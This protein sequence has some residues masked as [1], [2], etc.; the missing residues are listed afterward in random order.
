MY[1]VRLNTGSAGQQNTGK[2]SQYLDPGLIR[3]AILVPFD[4]YCAIDPEDTPEEVN[5]K[6]KAALKDALINDVDKYRAQI[7]GPFESMEDKTAAGGTQTLGF[8][9]V[10]DT[11]DAVIGFDFSFV[12]GGLEY[13]QKVKSFSG[14]TKQYKVVF[15]D[16][17]GTVYATNH[18]TYV[19]VAG[20]I[21]AH[22][23]VDGCKGI[24]LSRLHSDT[25]KAPNKDATANY[26]VSFA[27]K[28]VKEWNDNLYSIQTNEDML[29]FVEPYS[30]QDVVLS[31]SDFDS[32]VATIV[33]QLGGINM[34]VDLPALADPTNFLVRNTNTG[35]TIAC[36]SVTIVAGKPVITL[37]DM[38]PDYAVGAVASLQ[39]ATVAHL[40]TNELKYYTSNVIYFTLD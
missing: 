40:A 36:T 23:V 6:I 2:F 13:Y 14:K 12:D 19:P 34:A 24:E 33:A 9:R 26:M 25:W 35:N 29:S 18:T 1:T 22:D 27:L 37:D 30:V 38:D 11:S 15:I 39:L 21:P 5:G 10:V 8:G 7:I 3:L 16:E 31:L 20:N 4:W 28:S 17:K 32:S